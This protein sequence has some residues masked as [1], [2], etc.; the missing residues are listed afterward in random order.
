M[1]KRSKL[2]I[3][4]LLHVRSKGKSLLKSIQIPI[5]N[6]HYY[7]FILLLSYIS[8]RNILIE[9]CYSTYYFNI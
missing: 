2:N 6:L 9:L 1:I 3:L 8:L 7:I 4:T 5:Y